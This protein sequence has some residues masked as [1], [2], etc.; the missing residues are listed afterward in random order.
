MTT[1]SRISQL[2]PLCEEFKHIIDNDVTFDIKSIGTTFHIHPQLLT[3]NFIQTRTE[4]HERFQKISLWISSSEKCKYFCQQPVPFVMEHFG[5]QKITFKTHFLQKCVVDLYE[6][7]TNIS[8]RND[9]QSDKF[10]KTLLFSNLIELRAY[11]TKKNNIENKYGVCKNMLQLG[12]TITSFS[13]DIKRIFNNFS[14][15]KL[16]K[17]LTYYVDKQKKGQISEWTVIS[18]ASKYINNNGI[19][20]ILSELQLILKNNNDDLKQFGQNCIQSALD[21]IKNIYFN[22]NDCIVCN[23]RNKASKYK[24]I[25]NIIKAINPTILSFAGI[26]YHYCKTL[27]VIR[28]CVLNRL[29]DRIQ[30][31]NRLSMAC[32]GNGELIALKLIKCSYKLSQGYIEVCDEQGKWNEEKYE[33]LINEYTNVWLNV[34]CNNCGCKNDGNK[35]IKLK[36]CH[37]CMMVAYC[38]K[39]CQKNGWKKKHRSVCNKSWLSLYNV[40]KMTLFNRM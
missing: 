30:E 35:I 11:E 28:I 9:S 7:E 29:Y 37:G 23:C 25:G 26:D 15:S 6:S 22:G 12:C 3:N 20:T 5:I 8:K 1:K 24:Y 21:R 19:N 38:S 34:E 32:Y 40:L 2:V 39:K 4:F 31:L 10:I 16:R 33:K 18:E 27:G 17:S 13:N 36:A 14:G